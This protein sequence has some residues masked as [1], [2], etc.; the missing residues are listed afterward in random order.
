MVEIIGCPFFALADFGLR[1]FFYCMKGRIYIAFFLLAVLVANGGNIKLIGGRMEVSLKGSEDIRVNNGVHLRDGERDLY[2]ATARW[3]RA[4][5][6]VNFSGD[7][8]LVDE[9]FSLLSSTLF[10]SSN[11]R[12][13]SAGG[14]VRF[15]TEDS[16]LVVRG[17]FGEY[18]GDDSL[19]AMSGSPHLSYSDSAGN[20]LSLDAR[21]LMYFRNI[22]LGVAID[23]V[24]AIFTD[25]DGDPLEINADS[26][27]YDFQNDIMMAHREVLIQ[28]DKLIARCDSAE[29]DRNRDIVTLWGSPVITDPNSELRAEQFTLIM[30]DQKP[31]ELFAEGNAKGSFSDDEDRKSHFA[32]QDMRFFFE[33][34]DIAE[35]YL[36]R[37]VKVDYKPE[38]EDTAYEEQLVVTGDSVAVWFVDKKM[39]SVRVDGG[40]DGI[41]SRLKRE[42]GKADSLFFN[43]EQGE[44]GVGSEAVRLSGAADLSYEDMN[45][46]AHYVTYNSRDRLLFAEALTDGDTLTG[47][48][49]L[50]MDGS[51]LKGSSMVYD[52]RTERGRV[53]MGWSKVDPGYFWGERLEKA[54]GD[55]LYAA[56]GKFTT[57]DCETDTVD[58]H[59]YSP[60]I[61]LIPNDKAFGRNVLLYIRELP[62]FYVP[63]FVFPTKSG[64]RSGL[65]SFDIGQF[66]Q[67]RRFIRN[68][69]YYIAPNDYMD[70]QAA[71]DFDEDTG[72][73][74]H[75]QFRYALRYRFSGSLSGSYNFNR[76]RTWEQ[77]SRSEQWRF[78]FSHSQTIG[79]RTSIRGS[80]SFVSSRDF[81]EDRLLTPEETMNQDLKSSVYLSTRIWDLSLNAEVSRNEN[82]QTGKIRESL[83][84]IRLSLPSK[85]LGPEDSFLEDLKIKYSGR[86]IN[87]IDRDSVS[88]ESEWGMTNNSGL[89]MPLRWKSYFTLTP[90]FNIDVN[91]YDE[92]TAGNAMPVLT[93]WDAGANLSTTMYGTFP[94][95][96][97]PLQELKH[98]VTPGVSYSYTPAVDDAGRFPSFLGSTG[99]NTDRQSASFSLNNTFYARYK[100]K[101]TEELKKL[102]LFS[103]KSSMSYNFED[104]L[105]SDITS[106][107]SAKPASFLN[108][109]LSA[110]HTL[111]QSGEDKPS[112]LILK[113]AKMTS[114]WKLDGQLPFGA[115]NEKWSASVTHY[116]SKDFITDSS[117]PQQWVKLKLSTNI[118]KKWSLDY[119]I[120]YDIDDQE[121]ISQSFEIRRDMHCWAGI[122]KW[123]P[124]GTRKG[125]YFKV[126]IK[127][128][129]DVKVEG[130]KGGVR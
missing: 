43:A 113:S 98:I 8:R 64:R 79:E 116:L 109:S 52:L 46:I 6:K 37:Q 10:Y 61:K 41:Y 108:L 27:T 56:G 72:L 75:G 45:L 102:S 49:V 82:L 66:T 121:R 112:A 24:E 91:I 48:P 55:T 90:N 18:F 104:D 129:P 38:P 9:D 127:D 54:G 19:L 70:M 15:F 117:E 28:S 123:Y 34:G 5:D 71:F 33:D 21:K 110:Y 111:Y 118:T 39:D 50:T 83:P 114:T 51:S 85:S 13:A 16:S 29:F 1:L 128:L 130:S 7:V 40:V 84:S 68:V 76:Q 74:L 25:K 60:T 86:F 2:S 67:D 78:N 57:C 63:F 12:Y 93:K 23:D 59:F 36:T 42:S 69:G 17:L 65:L 101:D 53:L 122:L 3:N 31:S 80:G 120:Y 47:E 94:T 30:V 73:K 95:R 126:Y 100:S 14:D 106:T 119:N 88:Y 105:F 99:G 107:A 22:P 92:D 62:V 4:A 96:I 89:S 11:E 26:L 20:A 97:G 103:L 115:V 81:F 124:T 87:S 32:S 77:E 44:F 58:Y 125:F 35:A